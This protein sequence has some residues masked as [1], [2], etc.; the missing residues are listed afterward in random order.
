MEAT[1]DTGKLIIHRN[2]GTGEAVKFNPSSKHSQRHP[3]HHFTWTPVPFFLF[4][5]GIVHSV[6]F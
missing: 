2:I 6:S 4:I 5:H 3:D 1:T